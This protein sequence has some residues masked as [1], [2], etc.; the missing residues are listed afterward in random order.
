MLRVKPQ[1]GPEEL[2]ER[3]DIVWTAVG[4][5]GFDRFPVRTAQSAQNIEHRCDGAIPKLVGGLNLRL[6]DI[7]AQHRRVVTYRKRRHGATDVMMQIA[8]KTA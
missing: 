4:K 6:I 1:G 3:P 5:Q 8:H 7:V 2:F